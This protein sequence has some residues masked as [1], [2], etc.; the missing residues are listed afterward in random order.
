MNRLEAGRAICRA[1]KA[2]ADRQLIAG[3]EG[4]IA[5]RLGADRVLVTPR[6]AAKGALGPDDLVEVDLDGRRVRGTREAST[7]VRMH[8]TILRARRDVEA[9]VHAHPPVATGFA[10]AGKTLDEGVLPELIAYVGPVALAPYGMTGTG[11]LSERLAP[12]IASHEAILLSNH[13]A[14]TMGRSL[15]DALHR[16]ESLEQGARILLVARLLGGPVPLAAADVERLNA[17]REALW[18]RT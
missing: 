10:A 4:N 14:V 3:R 9:V 1:G 18:G 13:G 7:E 11:E 2:L 8:L 15:D 6:G 17:L 16:M 12:L 5:L